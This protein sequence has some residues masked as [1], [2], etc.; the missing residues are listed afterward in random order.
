MDAAGSFG[1]GRA[2][3]FT[4]GVP[5]HVLGRGLGN[6]QR[7]TSEGGSDG[8][9]P[10]ASHSV[11]HILVAGLEAGATGRTLDH[12]RL[13]DHAPVLADVRPRKDRRPQAS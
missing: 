4:T 2:G 10:A 5:G 13:S 8:V 9:V 7:L 1:T 12:G 11:D 3:I 6:R